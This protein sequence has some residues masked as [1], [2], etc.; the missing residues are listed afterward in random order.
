[1]CALDS[2]DVTCEDDEGY[3]NGPSEDIDGDI[4]NTELAA[5]NTPL[6]PDPPP[7]QPRLDPMSAETVLVAAAT[8]GAVTVAT[9][10]TA[11]R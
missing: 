11:R 4:D 9:T 2:S 5:F 10:P 7:L 3:F 6:D 1:M 8:T